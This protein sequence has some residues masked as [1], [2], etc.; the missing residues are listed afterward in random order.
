MSKHTTVQYVKHNLVENA[1]KGLLQ[2]CVTVRDC[3]SGI[4]TDVW[5]DVDGE[6]SQY[7]GKQ[8]AALGWDGD[9]NN[10]ESMGGIKATL[11]SKPWAK[12]GKSGMNYAL[13]PLK[14]KK[15]LS[16]EAKSAFASAFAAL[17]F[18]PVEKTSFNAAGE[19]PSPSKAAE[20]PTE[21]EELPF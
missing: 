6:Y 18:A 16:E 2:I 13:F 1:D 4:D 15:P 21:E 5:M 7:T 9:P 19:L 17:E 8:L 3:D 11:R 20:Q 10:L 12:N 14:E